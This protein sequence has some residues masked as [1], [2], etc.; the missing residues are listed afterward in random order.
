MTRASTA[1]CCAR[2]LRRLRSALVE[3]QRSELANARCLATARGFR[4]RVGPGR[5][6]YRHDSAF[7]ARRIR[8]SITCSFAMTGRGRSR[9]TRSTRLRASCR[10]ACRSPRCGSPVGTMASG[11]PAAR[12][13]AERRR[14]ISTSIS[15]PSKPISISPGLRLS[16]LHDRVGRERWEA[17][18]R[19]AQRD[20]NERA[21]RLAWRRELSRGS[22]R[23]CE[24]AGHPRRRRSRQR[25]ARS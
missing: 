23:E 14:S 4:A 6:R 11:P 20:A 10:S 18:L 2:L 3:R 25:R 15:A 24:H 12:A 7:A 1:R 9:A 16:R 22:T 21:R 5:V 13:L 19:L 17:S 8:C